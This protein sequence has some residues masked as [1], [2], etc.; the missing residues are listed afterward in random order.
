MRNGVFL[1]IADKF[2]VSAVHTDEDIERVL[3]AFHIGVEAVLDMQPQYAT[4]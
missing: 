2:Y 1:G 4:R 3:R